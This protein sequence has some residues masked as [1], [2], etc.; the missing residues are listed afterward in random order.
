MLA[1][2]GVLRKNESKVYLTLVKHCFGRTDLG[3]EVLSFLQVEH[4]NSHF[5]RL[6]GH[7]VPDSSTTESLALQNIMCLTG[8]GHGTFSLVAASP[9]D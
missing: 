7:V 1:F 2:S 6:Y 5:V 8:E 4:L 3:H 9:L